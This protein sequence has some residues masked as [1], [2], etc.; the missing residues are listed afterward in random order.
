MKLLRRNLTDFEYRPLTGTEEVL[1]YGRH[2]GRRRPKYGDPECY[3]GNISTPNGQV[4]NQF[5]GINTDYTHVLVMKPADAD[6]KETG[7]IDW[8][9]NRYEIKAVR[10]SL[11]FLSVALKK[12]TDQGDFQ[13][14]VVPEE[15]GGYG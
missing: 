15:I 9:G 4:Q 7:V 11:N 10:P 14:N 5:L 1:E 13:S 3:Q 12:L 8:N 6:I 2:T